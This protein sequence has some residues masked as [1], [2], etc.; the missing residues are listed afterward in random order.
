VI[1]PIFESEQVYGLRALRVLL[2]NDSDISVQNA[3]SPVPDIMMMLAS[4]DFSH[5]YIP[6]ALLL[7]LIAQFSIKKKKLQV[8]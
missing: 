2:R 5:S 3:L 7:A 8:P 6:P 4:W 1:E